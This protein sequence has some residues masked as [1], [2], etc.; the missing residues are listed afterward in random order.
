MHVARKAALAAAW[1]KDGMRTEKVK[2][3]QVEGRSL[4]GGGPR[5]APGGTNFFM[6]PSETTLGAPRNSQGD[7]FWAWGAS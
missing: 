2:G 4:G 7:T 6:H 1:E 3:G 5:V